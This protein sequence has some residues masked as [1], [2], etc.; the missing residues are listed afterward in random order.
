M[1]RILL[2]NAAE[3]EERR[4]ALVQDGR[5]EA[6]RAERAGSAAPQRGNVYKGE[7]VNLETGIGAAFVALGSGRNGFLHMSDCLPRDG[8][9]PARIEEHVALGDPVL[10]RCRARVS[11]ARDPC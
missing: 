4:V 7:V 5:L 11:A 3:P 1:A 9:E 8:K 2:L 10:C 6:Y